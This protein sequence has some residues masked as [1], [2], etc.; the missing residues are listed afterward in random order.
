M[1]DSKCFPET[2]RIRPVPLIKAQRGTLKE[3]PASH[4]TPAPYECPHCRATV[5]VLLERDKTVFYFCDG[6]QTRGAYSLAEHTA[7]T[8]KAR[9]H[10]T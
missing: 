5:R 7:P 9:G 3:T 2:L 6:C 10:S 4:P 1:I 8:M